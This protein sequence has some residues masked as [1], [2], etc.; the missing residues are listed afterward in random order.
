[1]SGGRHFLK[2]TEFFELSIDNDLSL[3]KSLPMNLLHFIQ[4]NQ[5]DHDLE[6]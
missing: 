2:M 6:Q 5:I 1:M 3:P 4:E